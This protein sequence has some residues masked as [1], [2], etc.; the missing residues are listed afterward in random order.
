M[1]TEIDKLNLLMFK[2]KLNAAQVAKITNRAE[3]A[4]SLLRNG[5]K[6]IKGMIV[7]IE[8]HLEGVK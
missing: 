5:D 6:H 3:S 4:V 2:N 8:K 1:K 7:M